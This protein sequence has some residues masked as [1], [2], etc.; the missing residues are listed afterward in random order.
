MRIALIALTLTLPQQAA[1]QGPGYLYLVGGGPQP[2]ALVREFVGLAGGPGQAR[3]VVF[4]M[5][6]A[7]GPQSGEEKAVQ[8]RGLGATATN[9]Y[10]TR[11]DADADSVVAIVAQATGI[12]FGGGDQVR[13]A[14][15]LRDT[16]TAR[17][18]RARYQAGAV[19]G[20]TSAG[21]AVASTPMITGGEQ[22]RGGGRPPG[23]SSMV[24][25]T[26]DRDNVVTE[27]GLGLITNAI[28]DQHFVRR[29]RHNR[30]LSLVLE[31]S[32]KLGAGIDES[33]ALVVEPNGTWRVAGA[34]V[35]VIYDARRSRVSSTGPLGAT[36]IVTHILPAG[37]RF[38]PAT[39]AATL[40]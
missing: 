16:R 6:S 26:I 3:I 33:T 40:P 35:V 31:R 28:I 21:A 36:G 30:L 14:E 38:D 32:V 8:L 25:V 29:R 39:G 19:I 12:W 17:A 20:G 2:P 18:I 11:E 37:A 5:A 22:R 1:S 24:F 13:L 27:D 7:A 15:V 9:L 10:L 23:D 4:A 34:S